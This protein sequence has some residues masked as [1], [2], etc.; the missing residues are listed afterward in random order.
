MT[1]AEKLQ[2][3]LEQLKKLKVKDIHP[4]DRMDFC[5][6]V[7]ANLADS[8]SNRCYE[9]LYTEPEHLDE[10]VED[11]KYDGGKEEIKPVLKTGSFWW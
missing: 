4:E 8:I 5:I 2:D 10:A 1:E 7:T 3:I 9:A 11:W 6:S